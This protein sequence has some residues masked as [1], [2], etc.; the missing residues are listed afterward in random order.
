MNL[1]QQFLICYLKYQLD[2][3]HTTAPLRIIIILIR[4]GAQRKTIEPII[5]GFYQPSPHPLKSLI[6]SA[7]VTLSPESEPD[8]SHVSLSA[9]FC[10]PSK[11]SLILSITTFVSSVDL[12]AAI[13]VS[14]PAIQPTISEIS[15]HPA[16]LLL[17]S[18]YPVLS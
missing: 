13:I 11:I 17:P 1:F 18:P 6:H 4:S 3:T 2:H 15:W 7:K 14:S 10:Y 9:Y 8:S 5:I 16:L 12:I